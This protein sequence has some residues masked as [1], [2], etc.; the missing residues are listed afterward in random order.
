MPVSIVKE[1]I[2]LP[3][4]TCDSDGNAWLT[5]K[6]NLKPGQRHM[7]QQVDYFLDRYPTMPNATGLTCEIVIS[8]YPSIPTDMPFSGS[9]TEGVK[10]YPAG[11][12]DSVLFKAQ[13]QIFDL[14]NIDNLNR[15]ASQFPSETIAAMNKSFFYTDH[16]YINVCLKCA[17]DELI[18]GFGMSFMFVLDDK[19]TS[20]LEHS[21]GVLS[22]Q[23]DAMCALIM[24]NGRMQT[25]NTLRGNIFPMWRYGGI[26]PAYMTAESFWLKLSTTDDEPMATTAFIRGSIGGA[27]QMGAFDAAFGQPKYPDWIKMNLN[28]GL[29]SG[30]IR[31]DPVP[32]KYADNGNTRM[33]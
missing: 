2:E 3:S 30:P 6:I 10:S 15:P 12:D 18:E 23:H 27:R 9:A 16:I 19:G 17:A 8:A 11:G 31:P 21:L 7:L 20:S 22:E 1:T 26:R 5:K 24:S 29:T 28:Q 32:L 25:I 4:V 14:A 33:F 13:L